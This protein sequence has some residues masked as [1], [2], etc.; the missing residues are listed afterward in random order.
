LNEG[1][2]SWN[3]IISC[4]ETPITSVL[5][6]DGYVF[7]DLD[8]QKMSLNIL[9]L[10][11]K[12]AKKNKTNVDIYTNTAKLIDKKFNN[13]KNKIKETIKK[14]IT[15]LN[16]RLA[17]YSAKLKVI[18]NGLNSSFDFHDRQI[19]TNYTIIDSGQGF[20]LFP[21]SKSKSTGQI[22]S[23]S[24]FEKFTY[25]RLRGILEMT[26]L[27]K[28]KIKIEMPSEYQFKSYPE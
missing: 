9:P 21:W 11:E 1:I 12:L 14:K 26:K 15:F 2:N 10:I 17:N 5:I 25:D 22:I 18:S 19:V 3:E 20:N 24:I 6:L 7:S 16:S 13:N 8:T 23:S 28:K 4:S 27:Y